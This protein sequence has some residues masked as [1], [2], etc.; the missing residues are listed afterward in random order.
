MPSS[1]A[2]RLISEVGRR[3]MIISRMRSERSSSSVMAV[4]PRIA[5][6][7]TFQAARAFVERNLGPFG[8]IEAGFF[9]NFAASSCT[10]FLQ[11]SQITRTRRCAMMQFSAETKL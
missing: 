1:R 7:G 11:F 6:A 4:R 3:L 10:C 8:R 5:A 9:Q 2:A